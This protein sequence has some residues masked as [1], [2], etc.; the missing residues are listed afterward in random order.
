MTKLIKI[1]LWTVVSLV[2]LIVLAS[3]LLPIL[4]DPNDYKEEIAQQVHAKTGRTLTIDGDIDLS[5][6]LPLSVSLD[7]GKIELSNAKGFADKPFARMQGAS[8]FVSIMPLLTDNRLDVGEIKLEGMELNLIKNKQGLTNWAD[9]S[10]DSE[11]TEKNKSAS[12]EQK[13]ESNTKSSEQASL[14]A[15][16]VAGL[17][18]SDAIISWTDQQANQKISLSKSNIS[19]SELIED[20]PFELKVSTHIESSEPAIKGDFS[21]ET[22][23]TISLSQQMFKLP[24]TTLSLDLTGDTLPGGANKTT[25]VGDISFDGKQQQLDISKMKLSSYEMVINGLFHAEK[26]DSSPEFSGQISIDKFSPKQ[27][28]ATLGSALPK[29]KEAK[30]LS[31]SDAKIT[32]KG[33]NKAVTISSLEANLDETSLK[34]TATI[35]DFQKPH[36]GFDLTLNQLNLDYYALAEQATPKP[37]AKDKTEEKS[38]EAPKK[39]AGTQ[40]TASKNAPIFPVETLRQLNLN[41]KLTI[42]EFIAAGAKMTNVVIVLKGKNGVVQLAPL[43]ANLYDGTIDLNTNINV[44]GKTPKLKIVNQLK[45]VQI[46]DLLQATT[47]SQEFTGEANIKT[48]ITSSGNTQQQL[49]R[50]SNGTANLLVTNGKIKKL[51]I[52]HT[53]RKA[54]ALFKGRTLASSTQEKNTE[55]TE[56]KGTFNIKKGVVHNNDLA[57]KSPVMELTGKGYADL[58]K[59]YLDYTLSVKLLNSLQ[60]D[61]KSQ[62]TDYKSKEIPYTIKGKFSELS[63]E[64]NVSK[65]LEQEVKKSVEKKLNKKL[66]EKYGD[67]FKGLLKF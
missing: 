57:S 48:N 10:G 26:L 41:G 49:T 12:T 32:F 15:I 42:A 58:P 30:A 60:I 25:L 61:E 43:K 24:G 59:E 51:D 9:L 63:E 56:L 65:V 47:G 19:I 29:M 18:I 34:G 7:L 66:E 8:L 33:N 52:L 54:D 11:S 31:S 22:T 5:I 46:G 14:P 13:S 40:S 1:L 21:L 3:V 28:A 44:K 38:K 36:Y 37:Q 39:A 2:L 55:F 62:G 27:L 53:L 20:K 35:T 67:K 23:P 45:N 50:N 17:T 16:S 64:A 4:V 6:S